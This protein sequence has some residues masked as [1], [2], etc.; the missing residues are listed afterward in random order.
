VP[1]PRLYFGCLDMH[2]SP[3]NP[4]SARHPRL[5]LVTHRA[6]HF[7]RGSCPSCTHGQWSRGLTT[8]VSGSSHGSKRYILLCKLSSDAFGCTL[9]PTVRLDQTLTMR[10]AR[11]DIKFHILTLPYCRPC[12]SMISRGCR[13]PT[14]TRDP[15]SM[16][17][18]R[19]RRS[20]TLLRSTAFWRAVISLQRAI[21]HAR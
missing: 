18:V 4:S 15:R 16:F 19:L 9:R 13:T 11:L 5:P 6:S 7:S 20:Q 14:R 12:E 1:V 8:R 10:V 21:L 17:S 3:S 2:I